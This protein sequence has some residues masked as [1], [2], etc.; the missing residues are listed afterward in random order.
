M[1]KILM[2]IAPERFRDEEFFAPNLTAVDMRLW[3]RVPK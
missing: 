3:L 2:I 1:A